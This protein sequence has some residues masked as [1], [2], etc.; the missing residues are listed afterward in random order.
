M[1]NHTL[2]AGGPSAN[3]LL[4]EDDDG[5]RRL[6]AKVLR[7]A[8]YDV[9]D[10]GRPVEAVEFL[11]THD[12]QFDVVVTDFVMPG[13]SGTEAADRI[14]VLR[15]GVSVIFM[16]GYARALIPA[17]ALAAPGRWYLSKPFCGDEL[18]AHVEAAVAFA[19]AAP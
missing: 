4:I 19:G 15:P 8:G 18:L 14:A 11:T 10:F 3:I 16:S 17:A 7:H 2:D 13:I 12:L 9:W 1:T 6:T 5:V